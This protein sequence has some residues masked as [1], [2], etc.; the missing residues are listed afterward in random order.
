MLKDE[1]EISMQTSYLVSW[2]LVVP[3]VLYKETFIATQQNVCE[4]YKL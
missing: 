3:L 4:I 2:L 1:V